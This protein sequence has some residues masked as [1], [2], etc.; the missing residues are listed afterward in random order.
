MDQL[1][2]YGLPA[3]ANG[4]VVQRFDNGG[5]VNKPNFREP[6]NVKQKFDE[7]TTEML[8]PAVKQ[9]AIKQGRF[10]SPAASLKEQIALLEK[11]I[12]YKEANGIDASADKAELNNLKAQLVQEQKEVTAIKEESTPVPKELTDALETGDTEKVKETLLTQ[13]GPGQDIEIKAKIEE[14]END[15]DP[16]G[17]EKDKLSELE[18]LVR[19]RSDLYKKILGDPK[20]GLKQQGLLQLAQFGLNLASARGG[21]FAEKIAKSAK[22]PLQTFAAL[23]RESLKD[24]RAI[25][26]LAIKGAE[27]EMARTQKVGTFGQLVNDILRNN[28]GM[29][30]KDAV[31]EAYDLSQAKSGK[32]PLEIRTEAYNM[33]Y[34]DFVARGEEP[35]DA[36]KLAKDLVAKD[37]G[38]TEEEQETTEPEVKRVE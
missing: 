14:Q 3:F 4:G 35:A 24:E 13:E 17:P 33:Y 34:A 10:F 12:A 8:D 20:E 26:M 25:E 6:I 30:R 31:K 2:Q 37:F 22:D 15:R 38:I 11:T 9:E 16:L 19:E 36:R 27:D 1:R 7:A 5:D 21:T 32:T 29:D 18:A 28:P 23:G